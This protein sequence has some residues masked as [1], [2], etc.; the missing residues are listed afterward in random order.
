MTETF[1]RPKPAPPPVGETPF[2]ARMLGEAQALRS[3]AEAAFLPAVRGQLMTRVFE[4]EN[5]AT[6]D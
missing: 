6:G 3:A 4:F 5:A 1:S 2:H